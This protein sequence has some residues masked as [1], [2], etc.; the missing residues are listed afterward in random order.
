[1]TTDTTTTDTTTND[2]TTVDPT[3]IGVP[4]VDLPAARPIPRRRRRVVPIALVS[5]V[6]GG[7][8]FATTLQIRADD[9][10]PPIVPQ[11]ATEA[12]LR[13]AAEWARRME[14]LAPQGPEVSP[15]RATEQDLLLAAEWARR[16]AV[17]EAKDS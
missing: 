6:V 5:I 9:D 4:T 13:L 10:P 8:A 14:A 11:R 12:D 3:A 15:R 7:V 2:P 1:M 17:M 16:L